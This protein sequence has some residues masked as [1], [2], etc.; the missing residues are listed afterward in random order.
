MS[1]AGRLVKFT[2]EIDGTPDKLPLPALGEDCAQAFQQFVSVNGRPVNGRTELDFEFRLGPNQ[3]EEEAVN[4]WQRDL[5]RL[6]ESKYP[7]PGG[8]KVRLAG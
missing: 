7:L 5:T 6:I 8:G 1:V 2:L 3:T 4:A